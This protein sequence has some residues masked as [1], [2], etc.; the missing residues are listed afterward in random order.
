MTVPR[1]AVGGE[2]GQLVGRLGCAVGRPG[3]RGAGPLDRVSG[4]CIASTIF[5]SLS[6]FDHLPVAMTF[7]RPSK[8]L[9]GRNASHVPTSPDV[10]FRTPA[11]RSAQ[12]R[13]G[14]PEIL[15]RAYSERRRAEATSEG[16]DTKT[17]A[18]MGKRR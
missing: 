14:R 7:M 1:P 3:V 16:A 5:H 6:A 8:V 15:V 2:D 11:G 13:T 12:I 18:R 4:R 17:G 10:N 9:V